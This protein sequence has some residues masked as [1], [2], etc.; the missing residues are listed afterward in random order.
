MMLIG[1][2]TIKSDQSD[3]GLEVK[4]SH[5]DKI[6]SI[7]NDTVMAPSVPPHLTSK[8][9]YKPSDRSLSQS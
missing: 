9:S 4:I 3:E 2:G 6:D 7:E 1:G 8:S 5:S